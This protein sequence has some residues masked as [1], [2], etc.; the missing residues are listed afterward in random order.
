MTFLSIIIPFDTVER[1]L[2]DCLDSLS[3]QNIDDSEIILI[4]NGEME[5]VTDLLKQYDNLNIIKW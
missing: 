3:E 4:L 5:D 1:Y 2:K